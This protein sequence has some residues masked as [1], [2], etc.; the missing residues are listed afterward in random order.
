MLVAVDVEAELLVPRRLEQAGEALGAR[1]RPRLVLT[2]TRC[3]AKRS[4]CSGLVSGRSG[5]RRGDLERPVLVQVLEQPGDV[6]RRARGPPPRAVDHEPQALGGRLLEREQLDV[7]HR[8]AKPVLDLSSGSAEAPS[9]SSRSVWGRIVAQKKAGARPPFDPRFRCEKRFRGEYSPA[10]ARTAALGTASS[11]LEHHR[12]RA[13]VDQR[14][15]HAGP[16]HALLG[17]E[18][19]AEPVVERLGLLAGSG[20]DVARPVALARVPVEGELADAEDLAVA[21]AARSSCPSASSKMRSART[22]SARRSA[23]A[24]V[25]SRDDPEQHQHARPDLRHPL[26]LDVDRRLADP[27]DQRPQGSRAIRSATSSSRRMAIGGTRPSSSTS[28]S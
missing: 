16:E 20:L 9:R 4:K 6:A 5:P 28:G 25:S 22:L 27:L 14:D 13:V 18:S 15:A 19:L 23:S 3:P 24:S 10:L 21:R 11:H 8:V 7:G 26:A 2:R 12:D 17:A 1:R